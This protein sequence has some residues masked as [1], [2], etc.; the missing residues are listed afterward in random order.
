MSQIG[1]ALTWNELA[2]IYDKPYRARPAR[3]LPMDTVFAWAERQT[4]RF[5]VTE[6]GSIHEIVKKEDTNVQEAPVEESG[7]TSYQLPRK[8]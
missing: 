6:D 5:K 1:P 8:T 4:D 2:D 3:T 7:S